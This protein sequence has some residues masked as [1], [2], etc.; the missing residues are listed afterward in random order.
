MPDTW[1]AWCGE[2]LPDDSYYTMRRYCGPTCKQA[3]ADDL[4]AEARRSGAPTRKTCQGC[5]H[6]F[7]GRPEQRF[8]SKECYAVNRPRPA[9][10][11]MPPVKRCAGCGTAFKPG[12][13]LKKYCSRP[14][15]GARGRRP[16]RARADRA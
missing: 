3:Y 2:P 10:Q 7:E 15:Y 14:C 1:C 6:Y 8:C 16:L 11:A 4:R 12:L 5:G 9:T 13:R